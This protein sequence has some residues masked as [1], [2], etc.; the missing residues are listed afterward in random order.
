MKLRS[1]SSMSTRFTGRRWV[2]NEAKSQWRRLEPH[3]Q[4]LGQSFSRYGPTKAGKNNIFLFLRS[5]TNENRMVCRDLCRL[6]VSAEKS[7]KGQ[8][9]SATRIQHWQYIFDTN[10]G[11]GSEWWVSVLLLS[12]PFSHGGWTKLTT[13]QS[14]RS[15]NIFTYR[16][17]L[18]TKFTPLCQHYTDSRQ[19]LKEIKL[20]NHMFWCS[21]G[22]FQILKRK[23]V[24]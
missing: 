12:F 14:V 4:D 24:I 17:C 8:L 15:Q 2:G 13:S 22:I 16:R 10:R 23:S 20:F 11:N 6:R 21:N 19:L 3:V 5:F 9:T 7:D 1:R 18:R